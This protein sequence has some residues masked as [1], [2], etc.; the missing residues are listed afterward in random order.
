VEHLITEQV[1]VVELAELEQMELDHQVE[2]EDQLFLM[3]F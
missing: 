1:A 2:L 3:L